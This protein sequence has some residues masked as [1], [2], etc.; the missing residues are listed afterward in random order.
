VQ[1]PPG[2]ETLGGRSIGIVQKLTA[3][4]FSMLGPGG[5]LVVSS[6]LTTT[7]DAALM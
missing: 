2:Q 4:L 7:E 3:T 6:Y 1:F 5:R